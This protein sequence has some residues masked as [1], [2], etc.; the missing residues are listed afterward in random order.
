M[1]VVMTLQIP[2]DNSYAALPARFYTRQTAVPV[3]APRLIRFNAALADELG[4][5]PADEA[6]LAQVFAGNAVTAVTLVADALEVTDAVHALRLV[7]AY[8]ERVLSQVG[9]V[10]D[11]DPAP[12]IVIGVDRVELEREGHVHALILREVYLKLD[13]LSLVELA[14]AHGGVILSL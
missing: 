3:R 9:E 14:S 8:I 4:I 6:T 2:F 10:L 13:G 5:A 12:I 11:N 1:Y 7:G